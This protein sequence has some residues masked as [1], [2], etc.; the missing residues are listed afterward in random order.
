MDPIS[1]AI[2]TALTAGVASGVTKAGETLIG[3]AYQT[4]K[5]ALIK[6]FGSGSK[7]VQAVQALEAKPNSERAQKKL[8]ES[9]AE[10]RGNYD[11]ELLRLASRL[12]QTINRVTQT[13]GDHAIQIGAGNTVSGVVAQ[14]FQGNVTTNYYQAP[15]APTAQQLLERGVQLMRAGSYLESIPILN[16]SL[17]STPSADGYYYIALAHLTGRRPKVLTYTQAISIEQ[18]LRAA[19]NMNPHNAHYWYFL[20]LL[21]EDFFMANGFSEGD[22]IN[23][24]VAAGDACSLQRACV[25]ELLNSAPAFGSVVYEYLQSRIQGF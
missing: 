25:V 5:A 24:I 21:M 14:S 13:A 17:L 23:D 12:T 16:Q 10:Q 11:K 15:A 7:T 4:L 3:D 20:A 9:M 6:K 8:S 19:C 22:E 2:I 1:L 18:K